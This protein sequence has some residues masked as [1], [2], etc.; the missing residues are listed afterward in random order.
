[1]AIDRR[2]LET[3]ALHYDLR[4]RWY[5]SRSVDSNAVD[6]LHLVIMRPYVAEVK[7]N[8]QARD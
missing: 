4:S 3:G 5:G 7:Q 8:T 2:V 6:H 1:V